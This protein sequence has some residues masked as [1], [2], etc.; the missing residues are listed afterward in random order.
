MIDWIELKRK[1]ILGDYKSLKE[2]SDKENINYG[3]LRKKAIGWEQE[4]G[5]KEEQKSNKIIEK[6]IEKAAEKE[7]DRNVRHIRIWDTILDKVEKVLGDELTQ[8]TDMFG[9]EHKTSLIQAG[10]LE[11]M[12][13]IIEKAQKGHRLAE[14]LDTGDNP[15]G[16]GVTIINDIKR[17]NKN[18]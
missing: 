16:I 13:K 14:G 9:K 8:Y 11:T 2:F 12:M 3:Y 6:T 10:K 15:K 4:R 1:Y 7:S 17:T 18:K 5:T